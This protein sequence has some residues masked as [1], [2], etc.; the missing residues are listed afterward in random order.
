VIEALARATTSMR[1]KLGESLGTVQTAER[2]YDNPVTTKSL[3]ALEAFAMGD[4]QYFRGS[5]RAALPFFQ[6]ATELDSNFAMAFAVLGVMY[7]N[8]GDQ[9]G[10]KENV[11]KAYALIDRVSERERLYITATHARA[12]G[13]RKT[14]GQLMELLVRR[15]PRD[16]M[17]RGNLASYY[18]SSG[19]LDKGLAEYE[20]LI[21]TSPAS[22]SSYFSAAVLYYRLDR[23]DDA[24]AVLDRGLM[25]APDAADLHRGLLYVAYVQDDRAAQEREIR[26][27]SGKPVEA[28]GLI[29]QARHAEAL[30]QYTKAS[31]LYRR[32]VDV[33]RRPNASITPQQVLTNPATGNALAG[34]CPD[35][36]A[37]P[38]VPPAI[39]AICGDTDAGRA[40]V[41]RQSVEAAGTLLNGAGAFVRG[42]VLQ[43]TGQSR[44]AADVFQDMVDGR[45]ANWGPEYAAA[46]V[47]LA[48][49]AASAGD[50]VRA[51]RA[52]EDFFALWKGAD[53]DIPLLIDA[54]TEYASLE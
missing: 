32:A 6:R 42:L 18:V 1:E 4:N 22:A 52:Y 30:G 10:F 54:R 25:H 40:L 41:E 16:A 27:F 9:S 37:R 8:V 5:A 15:Y 47:G 48:R 39:A 35:A 20:E 44:D 2:L 50:A 51:K 17:L 49:A 13:D 23:L 34:R 38:P 31:E 11:E 53:P 14:F 24:K 36:A 45:G 29:I 43:R 28:V 12:N 19:Q 7:S 46:H 26:W 33:A 21:R 3:E